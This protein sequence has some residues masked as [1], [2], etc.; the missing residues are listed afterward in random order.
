MPSYEEVE[1][2]LNKLKNNKAPGSD[3]IPAELIKNGGRCLVS[4]LHE[5]VKDIWTHE[6]MPKEWEISLICPLH[7]KGIPCVAKTIGA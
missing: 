3:G 2:A 6:K 7:K 1:K 5:I 4:Y